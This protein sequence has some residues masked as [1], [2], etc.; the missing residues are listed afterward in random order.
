MSL[1]EQLGVV[2]NVL[3]SEELLFATQDFLLLGDCQIRRF[4]AACEL[5]FVFIDEL[6][7]LMQAFVCFRRD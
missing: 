6:S 7:S 4:P 5:G 2:K 1:L 3:P